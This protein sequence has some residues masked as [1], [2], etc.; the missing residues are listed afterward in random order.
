MIRAT[1]ILAAAVAGLPLSAGPVSI[2]NPSFET[3]VNAAGCS[4]NNTLTAGAFISTDALGSGCVNADP[5][6]GTWT[7]SGDVGVWAPGTGFYPSVPNGQNVAF[8]NDGSLSQ[9]LGSNLALGTYTL[10]IYIGSRCDS[11]PLT[12][13]NVE[14]LAG[15]NIIG[16]DSD[17]ASILSDLACG[18]KTVGSFAL[19]TLVIP[20]ASSPLVGDPLEILISSVDNGDMGVGDDFQA[21][22]DAVALNYSTA[23]SN[24]PEPV[25]WLLTAAGLAIVLRRRYSK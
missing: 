21:A 13:Y 11:H 1:W 6:N 23:S 4:S 9:I 15:G 18:N 25:S 22:Y 7:P 24:V 17:N 12:N 5:L 19:D 16:S 3:V 10:S 20:V 2:T 8:T 14:L